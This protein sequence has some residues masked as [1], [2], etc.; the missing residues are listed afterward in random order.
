MSP[1]TATAESPITEA[2]RVDIHIEGLSK[3][4]GVKTAVSDFSTKLESGTLTGIVGESGSGKSTVVKLLMG[5]EKPTSGSI[6]I[7]G[8]DL[9]SV[10][11][12]AAG[13]RGY[14]RRV[15]LVS[16]DTTTTFDP[17]RRMR[18]SLRRPAQLLAG[19]D[20]AAANAAVDQ[21]AH[22]LG[23]RPELLDRFPGQVSGGQR[24]RM[25]IVRAL[26]ARPSLLVCDEA[27]SA[28]DVSVQGA[29]LNLIKTYCQHHGAGLL[30]V[31]HGLPAT[32]FIT[33]ELLVMYRGHLVE[34]G[35]TSDVLEKPKHEYTR[36]L[37]A[38]Y[39]G[40]N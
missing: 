20:H 18:E 24:Q 19:L 15:Q 2:K 32:A 35:A 5:L 38:A 39:S 25:S 3:I 22:E 23:I 37:V 7:D 10:M 30:F 6:H 27:V 40:R 8:Q 17:R 26:V 11:S 34:T 13:R 16:Q 14:R 4:Y 21:I 33:R 12:T 36:S 9:R 28:L 1:E 29:V 31:S